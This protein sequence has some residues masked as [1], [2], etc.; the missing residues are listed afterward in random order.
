[1][2]A[3]QGDVRQDAYEAAHYFFLVINDL[4]L[5]FALPL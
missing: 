2:R 3:P 1:M 5:D 4:Q